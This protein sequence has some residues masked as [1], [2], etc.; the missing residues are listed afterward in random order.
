LEKDTYAIEPDF[1]YARGSYGNGFTE[2]FGK[3]GKTRETSRL[4]GV[5]T[6]TRAVLYL[7]GKYWVVVDRILTDR[8]RKIEALWHYNPDCTVAVEEGSVTSTDE[9][10][11]NLRIVPVSDIE[12]ETEI[13]QGWYGEN[14]S[15]SGK[16]PNP[17]VIYSANVPA[18]TTFAW[19]LMPARGAV[20]RAAAAIVAED[21]SGVRIRVEM[22]GEKAV[23][24]TVPLTQ[25][26][27]AIEGITTE[28]IER[29][30][31]SQAG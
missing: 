2:Q 4:K 26:K 6:H 11:G 20:P 15:P 28:G 24:I 10:K 27:P 13:A 5:A 30:E 22:P 17:K 7:R 23:E 29:N 25:G 31:I 1:D 8:P 3:G 9:G 19:L 18:S 12:W 21:E 16:R 14:T